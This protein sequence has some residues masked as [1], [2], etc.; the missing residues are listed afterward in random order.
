MCSIAT[1]SHIYWQ[2]VLSDMYTQPAGRWLRDA[3][4]PYVCPPLC[5]PPAKLAALVLSGMIVNIRK[6]EREIARKIMEEIIKIG[7]FEASGYKSNKNME[8][9]LVKYLNS[10][11]CNFHQ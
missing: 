2:D 8:S 3:A 5:G 6:G 7:L 9:T 11:S 10:C 4:A 1:F